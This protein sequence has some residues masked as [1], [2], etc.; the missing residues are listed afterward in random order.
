[1]KVI[2]AAVDLKTWSIKHTC[3][4]CTSEIEVECKDIS[5]D[6]QFKDSKWRA[7]CCLCEKSFAIE[8]KDI[9]KLV[10]ADIVKH[11]YVSYPSSDW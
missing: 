11:R 9:P 1:M 2:K 3:P 8:E 6:Y 5:Y 7:T 10:Q 4:N